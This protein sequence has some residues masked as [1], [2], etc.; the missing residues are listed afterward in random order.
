MAFRE[1]RRVEVREVLRLW[2]R[3]EGLR[4]IARLVSLDRKPVR[5][6]VQAGEQAG[7]GR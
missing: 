2:L 1:V 3:G 7:L 5:R 4:L 6:Y